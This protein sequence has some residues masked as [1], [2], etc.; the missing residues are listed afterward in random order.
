MKKLLSL[1]PLFLVLSCD[2][3]DEPTIPEYSWDF[4]MPTDV[5]VKVAGLELVDERIKNGVYGQ[6]NS[7][8]IIKDDKLIFENY[9]N[10]ANRNALV[11][12]SGST[13]SVSS[14]L[15]GIALDQG[16]IPDINTPI[17]EL[18]PD[19]PAFMQPFDTTPLRSQIVVRDL[20]AMRAGIAWNELLRPNDVQNSASRM[21]RFDSWALYTLNEQMDAI[22]GAR[23]AYNS[24][25]M[26]IL[27][28]IIQEQTQG[29][30]EE[31][32]KSN[33]FEPMG[34][35]ASWTED[36][37]DV[38]NAASGM[39]TTPV[40]MA[41]LGY[42]ALKNGAWFGDQIVSEDYVSEMGKLQSQFTFSFD[43]GYGWW[44][45]SDFNQLAQ[46]S[47][48]NDIYF[49]WGNGGQ[50]IFVVP[51]LDMV[52]ITTASNFAP[53]F[54]E[55]LAFSMFLQEVIPAVENNSN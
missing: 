54:N 42:L 49:S 25:A 11:G 47:S 37:T 31:F 18:L 23:F 50:F 34:I 36:L 22:P 14:I 17:Q 53:D 51:H 55:E 5:D 12:L 43:Y 21:S 15:L 26:M 3:Q 16:V 35:E 38:T 28:Q 39:S 6:I 52:T 33:L 10:N 40:S 24:G 7:L 13:V 1:I 20:I 29:S 8:I 4:A 27:S 9:Y 44:R 32:A 48:E 2:F 46:L 19:V 30:L 45:F 41:K